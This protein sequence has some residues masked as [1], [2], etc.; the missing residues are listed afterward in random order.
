MAFGRSDIMSVSVSAVHGGCGSVHRRPFINGSPAETWELNC[1]QCAG[2]LETDPL[3][4][5][6]LAD[7]P[8]TYDEK[9]G[10]ESA[11]F[12]FTKNRD[13]ILTMALAKIAGLDTGDLMSRIKAQGAAHSLVKCPAGH[14]NFTGTKFCGECG[15][16]IG[17]DGYADEMV[18]A[19]DK[20]AETGR[21]A[22][23]EHGIALPP[24][25]KKPEADTTLPP[26]F[27]TAD[28][29][30]KL[31]GKPDRQQRVPRQPRPVRVPREPVKPTPRTLE[32]EIAS[33][34]SI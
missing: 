23:T 9:R 24:S 21:P 6:N 30:I 17:G 3:W 34:P 33:T 26:V 8:P 15:A 4:A 19:L 20:A 12:T 13:D 5:N 29:A 10:E 7:V 1:P 22:E 14:D 18:E 25:V 32:E 2:Y 28:N 27:N 11:N 16:R 31:A